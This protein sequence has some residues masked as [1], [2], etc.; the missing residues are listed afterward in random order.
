MD[1]QMGN[2]EVRIQGVRDVAGYR[3]ATILK[4]KDIASI[5]YHTSLIDSLIIFYYIMYNAW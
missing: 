4:S 2:D 3:N 5:R 1:L